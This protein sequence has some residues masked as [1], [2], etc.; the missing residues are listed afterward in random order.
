MA[1]DAA[2]P[3]KDSI[4]EIISL[5]FS[6]SFCAWLRFSRSSC[7][8]F[9]KFDIVVPLGILTAAQLY[10]SRTAIRGFS[11]EPDQPLPALNDVR[12]SNGTDRGT[13]RV[14]IGSALQGI[15]A[16]T[17]NSELDLIYFPG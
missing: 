11:A 8:A 3:F 5:S 9:C 4:P 16:P 17:R 14:R 2:K 13:G 6:T 1:A 12:N 7:S 10:S 15:E